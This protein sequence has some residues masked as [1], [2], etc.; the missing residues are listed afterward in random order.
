MGTLWQDLRYSLRTLRKNPGFGAIVILILALGV[1]AN[2]AIFSLVNA[3]LLRQLPFPEADRLV[4]VWEDMAFLGFPRNTPA[5]ANFVDWRKQNQVFEDMAAIRFRTLNLTGDGEPER[6][7]AR[8]VTASFFS[9]VRVRPLLGRPILD[10]DDRPEAG[11]VAVISYGLWQRRFGGE[12]NIVGKDIVLDGEK[13]SVIGVMPPRFSFPTQGID[14]YVPTGFDAPTWNRRTSHFLFVAARLKPGISWQRAQSDMQ[15]IAERLQRDYPDTNARVGATVVPMRE[16]YAGGVRQAFIVLLGAVGFVLLI[17]CANIANLL[18]ARAASRRKEM[19]VRAALGAG[20]WRVIRQLLTENILLAGIGGALGILLARASFTFLSRLIPPAMADGSPLELD[21]QVLAFSLLVSLAAGVLFGLAPAWQASRVDLNDALKQG[22]RQSSLAGGKRVRSLLVVAEVA[23]AVVLLTGAG[24]L[25]QTLAR[26]RGVDLGF[27]TDNSLVMTTVLSAAKYNKDTD[28]VAFARQVLDR[29][30]ALPGVVNAGYVSTLPLIIKGNT[31]G[32]VVEGHPLPLPGESLDANYREVSSEYLQTMGIPLRRGRFLGEQDRA[33][34]KAVAVIN[35]SMARKFWPREDALGKR[36][37]FTNDPTQTWHEV[38]GIAGDIHQMGLEEPP[39]AEL[40]MALQQAR[41]PDPNFLVVRT[42]GNPLGLAA[43]V[44]NEIRAVN[45][46]QPISNIRTLDDIVEVEVSQR[47]LQMELLGG[48]SALALLLATIGIYG[49][50]HYTVAQRTPE[51]GVRMA[52]GAR[53][54]DVLRMFV[55]Q[56]IR[57]AMIGVFTGLA[58]ALAL[59]R[60]MSS[61]LFGVSASDP[62]TYAAVTA[63]LLVVAAVASY[64]PARRA[65]RVDPMVA[66]HYE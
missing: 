33:E 5:P 3:V 50:L 26:L 2:T 28:R 12:G 56:G 43:A 39:R 45:S 20:R 11:K 53:R 15:T 58:A 8:G 19:A 9:I 25:M 62:A 65:S 18:L 48:F 52:L 38:V 22:G 51:I 57:L 54:Q 7:D 14:V 16:Q 60:V 63:V 64:I 24:L 47:H 32:F 13:Y 61:L 35:E 42:V 21:Y 40:Y 37:K 10:D 6:L 55:L 29:V 17:A 44:R 34:S 31:R 46:E 36:F 49:V 66:L 30:K 4:M 1:G 23:L 41:M 27:R 59:T